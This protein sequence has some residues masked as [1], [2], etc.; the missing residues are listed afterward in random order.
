MCKEPLRSGLLALALCSVIVGAFADVE[1]K[2]SGLTIISGDRE[3][4]FVVTT[5]GE[6]ESFVLFV[7]PGVSMDKKGNLKIDEGTSS[8]HIKKMNDLWTTES[9]INTI[10]HEEVVYFN[11]QKV[12]LLRADNPSVDTDGRKADFVLAM[13]PDVWMDEQGKLHIDQ[14]KQAELAK[15]WDDFWTPERLKNATLIDIL[16]PPNDFQPTPLNS[17]E[18]VQEDVLFMGPD[19]WMDEQGKLHIDQDKQAGLT[20]KWNDFWTPEQLRNANSADILMPPNDFQPTLLNPEK[21]AKGESQDGISG[22]AFS[23]LTKS[24]SSC[25]SVT[26]PGTT[27]GKVY[28]KHALTKQTDSCSGVAMQ[29]NS[30]QLIATA[31]HCVHSGGPGGAFHEG[32]TFIPNYYYG[33]QPAGNFSF[34]AAVIPGDWLTYGQNSVVGLNSDV[35]FVVTKKNAN[36]VNVMDAVG[37][38]NIWE[39]E[40]FPAFDAAIFGYPVNINNEQ[41]LQTFSSSTTPVIANGYIFNSVNACGFGGGS[42]GGAWLDWYNNNTGFG[43]LRS[44]T[45]FGDGNTLYGP[46]FSSQTIQL[47]NLAKNISVQ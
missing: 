8:E 17:E 34:A 44:V 31:A 25:N 32:W 12:A 28:F 9:L 18:I 4:G 15:K 33:A 14:N 43:Y 37:G 24:Q 26:N 47:Y 23:L 36:G 7:G 16:P 39:W 10:P 35:A 6:K 11:G 27:H 38:Q 45:S 30:K 1:G 2:K 20:K 41:I 3:N 21:I 46:V 22:V 5:G 40:G 19:V 29:S 42:S 13:G